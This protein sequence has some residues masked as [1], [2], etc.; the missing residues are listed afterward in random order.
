MHFNYFITLFP[1]L[2]SAVPLPQGNAATELAGLDQAKIDGAAESAA[3][4]EI[5]SAISAGAPEATILA[6]VDAAQSALT[7][8]ENQRAANQA[9]ATN[10]A[11]TDALN[12]LENLQ[13]TEAQPLI[14]TLKTVAGQTSAN[15]E[16]LAEIF[17]SGAAFNAAAKAA[18]TGVRTLP[19]T[20][21]S[22]GTRG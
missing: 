12:S 21:S 16:Q 18:A 4:V 3:Q 5:A 20:D 17:A 22:L 8:A 15:A 19:T 7:T 13:E 10:E 9:A 6:A 1:L 14:D 2:V 11:E